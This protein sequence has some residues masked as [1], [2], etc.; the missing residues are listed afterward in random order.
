LNREQEER[1]FKYLAITFASFSATISVYFI[2]RAILGI[3][4]IFPLGEPLVNREWP[5]PDSSVFYAKPVTYLSASS[6]LAW[7]FGLE[8][9]RGRFL[10]AS[11]YVIRLTLILATF[12][13]FVSG[14]ELIWNFSM[15]SAQ[16]A[17]EPSR[18][19]DSLVNIYPNPKFPVNFVFAT[20]MFA[21]MFF[22]AI[23]TLIFTISVIWRREKE[24]S[25]GERELY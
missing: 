25:S 5:S 14:Y 23:Y 21:A 19:P 9:L 13:A 20:K 7:L 3:D 15:W 22:A 24:A 6:L 4:P 2:V 12:F 16:V 17:L 10:R 8:S 1:L 18:S 11:E